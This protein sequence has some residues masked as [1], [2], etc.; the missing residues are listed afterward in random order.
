MHSSVLQNDK[1]IDFANENTVEVMSLQELKK[2]LDAKDK[3]AAQYDAVDEN[4][5]PVKYLVEFP[6]LTVEDIYALRKSKAP[7]YNETQSIPYTAIVDPHTLKQMRGLGGSQ[8]VKK[9]IELVTKMREELE[10]KHGK[11]LSR[12]HLSTLKDAKIKAAEVMKDKG[13]AKALLQFNKDSKKLL[14]KGDKIVEMIDAHKATLLEKAGEELDNAEEMI[15]NE[16]FAKAN[17]LLSSLKTALRKTDLEGRL[18]ELFALLKEKKAE[19]AE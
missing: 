3:K 1:Y 14:K 4:G 2:G 9:M 7:S 18:T 6:G 17:K 12:K 10:K 19:A 5:E 8:P 13:I 15:G 11:G 16:E